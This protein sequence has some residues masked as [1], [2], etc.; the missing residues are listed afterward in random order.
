MQGPENVIE[1]AIVMQMV[2]QQPVKLFLNQR[3]DFDPN[4]RRL[5]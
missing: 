2:F 3:M 4:M 1:V 5:L